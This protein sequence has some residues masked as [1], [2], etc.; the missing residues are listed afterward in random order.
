MK[1]VVRPL[2]SGDL[3]G[4]QE[5]R[6]RA[7]PDLPK[8]RDLEYY[9]AAYGWL[10][11][12]PLGDALHRWVAV[13]DGRVVG[14]LAAIPQ[15]YRI[16]GERVVA[17]TPADY[18]VLP[19]YGFQALT[20]MRTF[21]RATENCVACD[22]VPEVI[23]IQT[24][25]GAE[26]AGRLKYAV[27]FLNISRLPMPSLPASARRLLTLRE[28]RGS[29]QGNAADCP[30]APPEDAE[31]HVFRGLNA[32]PPPRPRAPIPEPAKRL[33][34]GGLQAVDEAL[35]AAFVGGRLKVQVLD[36]FD[37][38]FD[39]LFEKVAAA[40]PCIPEKDSA[41][42]SWRYGPGSPQPPATVLGVKG[43]EALLGYAVLMV[44]SSGK[45]GYVMDLTTLPQRRDVARALLRAAVRFFRRSGVEVILYAFLESP[46]S[47][48]P[49]DLWRLGFLFRKSSRDT[50]LTRFADQDLH[51][52]ARH[53]ANWSYNVGDGEATFWTI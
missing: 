6:I 30:G 26:D 16:N 48:T 31:G 49:E 23:R 53:A 27:K 29:V 45:D 18:K 13:A 43:G 20:L 44:T 47:P 50:L 42:L 1:A 2:E 21:F 38:S 11:S 35:G 5:L 14:H 37:E 17:H 52:S 41:F 40:V 33:L 25:P 36:G 19:P 7:L 10:G 32:M 12:H 4:V 22:M 24:R 8:T 9:T 34:N 39:E 46:D 51:R 28:E 3:E 15:W